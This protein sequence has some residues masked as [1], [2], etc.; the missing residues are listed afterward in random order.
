LDELVPEKKQ[1][2][3]LPIFVYKFSQLSPFTLYYSYH[4]HSSCIKWYL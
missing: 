3:L 1:N 2:H 4:L